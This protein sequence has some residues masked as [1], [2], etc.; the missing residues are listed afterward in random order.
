MGKDIPRFVAPGAWLIPHTPP[1]QGR[2][3][4]SRG[5]PGG[6]ATGLEDSTGRVFGA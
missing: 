5:Q 1:A 2:L 3:D 4:R 6:V